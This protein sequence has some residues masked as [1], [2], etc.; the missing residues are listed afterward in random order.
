M[1]NYRKTGKVIKG[2]IK[3]QR[4]TAKLFAKLQN[5]YN[6]DDEDIIEI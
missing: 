6:P 3:E 2:E 4:L 1:D 5:Q